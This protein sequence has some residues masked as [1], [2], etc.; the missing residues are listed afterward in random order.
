MSCQHTIIICIAIICFALIA[1]TAIKECIKNCYKMKELKK[2][3]ETMKQINTNNSAN[4]K[5]EKEA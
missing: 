3:Q 1:I 2:W 4:G 5:S